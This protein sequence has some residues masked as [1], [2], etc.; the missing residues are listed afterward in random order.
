MFTIRPA[1]ACVRDFDLPGP[2]RRRV[3]CDSCGEEVSDARE[4]QLPEGI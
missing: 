1:S 2:P 3:I 4:V